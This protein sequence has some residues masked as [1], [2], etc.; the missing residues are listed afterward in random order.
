MTFCY[1]GGMVETTV[2][3][4]EYCDV[5]AA[6]IKARRRELGLG[7]GDLAVRAGFTQPFVSQLEAKKRIPDVVVL[8]KLAN[9][10]GTTVAA[11]VSEDIFCAVGV[12]S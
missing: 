10:L 11:L 3:P 1:D 8:A 12:D 6:N 5:V 7:Q 9:A 4:E 2:K